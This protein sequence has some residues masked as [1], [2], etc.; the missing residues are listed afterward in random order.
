MFSL[1]SKE[2]FLNKEEFSLC[3]D[4]QRQEADHDF[5]GESKMAF[6]EMDG[7]MQAK[8]ILYMHSL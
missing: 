1:L 4:E 7:V 3:V 2:I 8:Q 5:Y 6:A